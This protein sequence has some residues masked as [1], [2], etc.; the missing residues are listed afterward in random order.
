MSAIVTAC[1]SSTSS[2]N[3]GTSSSG[4]SSCKGNGA[5]C[6]QT[7]EYSS[8][9]CEGSCTTGT[10]A[11][12][13]RFGEACQVNGDCQV[14]AKCQSNSSDGGATD[15]GGDKV[16]VQTCTKLGSYHCEEND[17]V[18]MCSG[19]TYAI[20]GTCTQCE[21][22]DS[23]AHCGGDDVLNYAQPGAPCGS[24]GG[25]ACSFDGSSI[26]ECQSGKWSS[27]GS[28]TGTTKCGRIAAG[29]G[30]C[31]AGEKQGCTSCAQ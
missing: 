27:V 1:S 4:G 14:D 8:E 16:C 7:T 2:S 5:T 22:F 30:T 12:T 21:G 11:S 19:G 17:K 15:A 26:L 9:C 18:S 25:S 23:V 13:K 29:T 24:P 6:S 28:C 3:G 10:C 20:V 31:P